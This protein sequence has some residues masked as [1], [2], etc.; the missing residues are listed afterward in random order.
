MKHTDLS[1]RDQMPASIA[2]IDDPW[3]ISWRIKNLVAGFSP[4]RT[5][6]FL[7]AYGRRIRYER[8]VFVLGAPRSGTTLLFHLLRESGEL[9]S[10]PGEGHNVWRMYHH[11]RYNGWR[12]DAVASGEVRLGERRFV[13]AYFYSWFGAQRFVEK[14]PENAL[15][16]PYLLDL[17]PDAVFICVRRNPCDV[18]S[19]L[20]DG[21]RN[22]AGRFRSYYVPQ[23][24]TIPEYPHR[25]RW[26]FVLVDGWRELSSAPLPRIAFT[27]WRQCVEALASGRELVPAERWLDVPLE[28]LRDC[29]GAVLERIGAHAGIEVD[30]ALRATLAALMQAPPNATSPPAEEKWRSRNAAELV[31]LLP[32]IAAA[33]PA[34][35]YVIDPGSGSYRVL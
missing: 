13:N 4:A 21:W 23:D 1:R 12:S 33:A 8:P 3:G 32:D 6:R 22:P 34:V 7:T 17:F 20:I 26:C 11:P 28:R 10:L 5:A 18:I 35:G 31:S 2:W 27:Q 9:A 25:R 24:L 16:I 19:S 29:P 15:R 14:T 30:D